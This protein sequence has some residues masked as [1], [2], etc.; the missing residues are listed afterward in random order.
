[1]K[2][3]LSTAYYGSI[4]FD[5]ILQDRLADAIVLLPSLPSHNSYE[6]QIKFW[7]EKGYH[8]F[9]PCYRGTYQSNGKFLSKNIVEDILDFVD[10]MNKGVVKNLWDGKKSEFRINKKILVAG[11]FSGAF[12]CGI[13]A[14]SDLFSHL[15]LASPIWDFESHNSEGNELDL[16]ALLDFIRK[17]YKNCYRF[18]FKS[19]K[20]AVVKCKE[21]H[22]N[23]YLPRLLES[24][25]PILV[26]HDPNDKNVSFAKTKSVVEKVP[27]ATLIEHY[28]GHGLS[29][30]PIPVFWKDVDKFIK[31]NYLKDEERAKERAKGAAVEKVAEEIEKFEK[32]VRAAESRKMDDEKEIKKFK[33]AVKK[34]KAQSEPKIIVTDLKPEEVPEVK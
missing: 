34:A 23:Y 4:F 15:I 1:M 17:S 22:P 33:R 27:N 10:E 12:A 31:I 5:Y 2:N 8:V 14:K 28:L 18:N 11:G 32:A 26:F 24:K 30:D 21:A 16:D 20:K 29:G 25:F 3:L 13:A 7:F 9:M 19:L 6:N